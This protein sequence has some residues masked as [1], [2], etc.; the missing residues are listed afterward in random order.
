V[1]W[2]IHNAGNFVWSRGLDEG[3]IS[4]SIAQASNAYGLA[5]DEAN[6]YFTDDGHGRV[7]RCNS[8][9]E[10]GE[11][12]WLAMDQPGP[13]LLAKDEEYLYWANRVPAAAGCDYCGTIVRCPL[14]G[15]IPGPE[16]LARDE[17]HTTGIAVDDVAIYWANAV[18]GKIRK[19][20]KPAP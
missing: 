16:V 2:T 20:A 5:V 19:L 1:F 10:L 12:T 13:G 18:T 4:V 8:V 15:C 3:S 6:A 7:G 9:D 17:S 14:E 11:P